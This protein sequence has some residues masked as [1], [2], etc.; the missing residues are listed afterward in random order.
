MHATTQ[1]V[2]FDLWQQEGLTPLSAM[3]PFAFF[4]TV[5]RKAGFDGF[6]RFQRSRYSLP[7]DY[8]GQKVHI[9]QGEGKIVIRVGDMIVAEHAPA[10][11]PG[12]VVARPEH[13]AALWKLSLRSTQAPPPRWQLQ[14][15]AGVFTTPL[16]VYQE[17]CQ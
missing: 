11:R 9:G 8:A 3:P 6:V 7:P 13:L 12:L 5:A 17:A 1:R 4:E 16:S 2:P 10:P 14:A 15:P